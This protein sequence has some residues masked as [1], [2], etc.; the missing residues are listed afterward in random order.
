MACLVSGE[1]MDNMS[2]SVMEVFLNS[3]SKGTEERYKPHILR[4]F[5]YCKSNTIYLFGG[6]L[7]KVSYFRTS[8]VTTT[9]SV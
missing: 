9:T 8:S 4:Y 2:E 1:N 7:M 3:W 5:A 6:N